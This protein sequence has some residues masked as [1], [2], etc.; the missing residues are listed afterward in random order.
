MLLPILG[1]TIALAAGAPG[2]ADDTAAPA[3][4]WLWSD[5]AWVEAPVSGEGGAVAW[6]VQRDPTTIQGPLYLGL[7]DQRVWKLQ[8]HLTALGVFR[9]EADG[10][11]GRE[12]AAA[13]VA[14]HK[15]A[16]MDRTDVWQYEDW[17]IEFDHDAILA[18]NPDEAD[19]LEVDLARQV[20]FVI[21]AGEIAAILPVS[22]GNGELY[23]SKNGGPGGGL[24]HATTPNGDFRL[25]KHIDGWRKNYLGN[26]YKPWYF[27]PYYAVHGSGSVPAH[28]ASHG[29][30]R[31]P[32]WESDHL[33]SMLK[34]GLRIHIWD[35]PQPEPETMDA[36]ETPATDAPTRGLA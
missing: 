32:I 36:T 16:G 7:D 10:V 8:Q 11:Y 23:W 2:S 12:T 29:C 33:D 9:G 22:S 19:R 21:R 28:P 5:V 20:L 4:A 18:R 26:L 25:I 14:V 13:V 30:I 35:E 24:V 6:R 31:V 34:L 1:L 27:T 3:T 15:L 17:K